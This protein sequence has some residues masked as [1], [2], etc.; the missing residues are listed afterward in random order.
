M[1]LW[2]KTKNRLIHTA[3]ALTATFSPSITSLAA[4]TLVYVRAASA[5]TTTTPTFQANATAA[6]VI[7]KGNGVALNPGDIAGAGHWLELVYDAT[8]DRWVL[9]NPATGVSNTRQI[10]S[11]GASVASNALTVTLA[12]T[13]LDFRNSTL[14]SGSPNTRYVQSQLSIVVPSGATLGTVAATRARLVILALDNGG[15]VELGI[16]NIS[17]GLIL[18]ETNLINTTAISASATSSSVVYSATARTNVPYRVVGFVDITEATAGTWA[19]APS[20][21][22][23]SGGQSLSV[24]S[25]IGYGQNY[26]DVSASRNLSTTY[27]NTTGRPIYVTV[28]MSSTTRCEPQ[29]IVNGV[30]FFG[31]AA[32]TGVYMSVSGI[33]PPD[34]AYLASTTAGTPTKQGWVELR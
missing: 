19:T 8:L 15:T 31:T 2:L 34:G 27:Y 23:G 29:L 17:G 7:V 4:G 14:S 3:D 24:L 13:T 18:D 11:V 10:Q 28:R 20:L 16:C 9:S 26:Q 21:V 32:E 33:V 5:N 6:K 12:P 30:S 1:S 22:Q 25:S